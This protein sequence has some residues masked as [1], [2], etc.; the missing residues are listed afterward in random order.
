M[1]ANLG[2]VIVETIDGSPPPGRVWDTIDNCWTVVPIARLHE[3]LNK[4]VFKCSACRESWV[5]DGFV[6]EH[7]KQVG[8]RFSL[9]QGAVVKLETRSNESVQ[10]CSGCG[11]GFRAAKNAGNRHIEFVL[12]AGPVHKGAHQEIVHRFALAQPSGPAVAEKQSSAVP[13][14]GPDASQVEGKR[15]RHRRRNRRGNRSHGRS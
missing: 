4:T 7:I 5:R 1:E 12:N 11:D 2:G 3:S 10:V 8:E 14:A 6:N 15:K 9:H 13:I